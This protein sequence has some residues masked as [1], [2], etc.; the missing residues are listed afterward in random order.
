MNLFDW[1]L[2]YTDIHER[3]HYKLTKGTEYQTGVYF[4]D[5]VVLTYGYNNKSLE[6]S[7]FHQRKC[8]YFY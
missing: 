5:A 8:G 6:V 1:I 3:S 4:D 2:A 7:I